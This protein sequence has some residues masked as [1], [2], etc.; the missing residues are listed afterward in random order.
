MIWITIYGIG[1]CDDCGPETIT[2]SAVRS[3]TYRYYVHNYYERGK[4]NLKLAASEASVKVYYNDTVT[5]YNVPNSAA[6]LWYVFE[7]D[8]SSGLTAVNNMGSDGEFT[9]QMS[10]LQQ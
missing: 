3:G 9:E 2:I 5:T 8:N 6:D 4:N 7:F 10:L 1:T